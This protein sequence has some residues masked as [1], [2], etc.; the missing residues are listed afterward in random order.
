MLMSVFDSS[1]TTGSHVEEGG[2]EARIFAHL[3]APVFSFGIKVTALYRRPQAR[4]QAAQDHL[5]RARS[6]RS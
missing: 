1:R 3:M 5:W 2:S 4:E 6:I